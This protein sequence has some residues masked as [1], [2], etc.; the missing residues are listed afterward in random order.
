MRVLIIVEAT[1]CMNEYMAE[2]TNLHR[3]YATIPSLQPVSN[4]VYHPI[5]HRIQYSLA[6]YIHTSHLQE[7][8]V[9]GLQT[10]D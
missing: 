9:A 8:A 10:V 4:V 1:I 7:P 2:K 3:T 6:H 5:T